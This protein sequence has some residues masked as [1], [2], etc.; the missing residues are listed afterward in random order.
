MDGVQMLLKRVIMAMGIPP[1][2]VEAIEAEIPKLQEE[3]PKMRAAIPAFATEVKARVESIDMRL[4]AL[5]QKMDQL[6]DAF[7]EHITSQVLP[8]SPP[9]VSHGPVLT[10]QPEPEVSRPGSGPS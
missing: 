2:A 10:G 1:G 9:E 7:C 6:I 3:I 4:A 5:E 8:P